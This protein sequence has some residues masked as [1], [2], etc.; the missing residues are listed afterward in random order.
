[1]TLLLISFHFFPPF[2]GG[3]I[4][5][6]EFLKASDRLA[7]CCVNGRPVR[8]FNRRALDIATEGE[9]KDLPGTYDTERPVWSL[10]QLYS[11]ATFL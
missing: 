6:D 9:S 3:S 5:M 7:T 8:Q 1:M 10:D 4:D 11:Q 2:S